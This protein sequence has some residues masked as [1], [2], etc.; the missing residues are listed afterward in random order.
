MAGK[1]TVLKK[2]FQEKDLQRLRNLVQGKTG[3]RTSTT[4]G[5]VQ[6]RVERREGEVWEEDGRKWELKGG[7]KQNISKLQELRKVNTFPIFCPK[8]KK[9]MD[10]KYDKPLYKIHQHCFECQ[11]QFEKELKLSGKYEEYKN[12]VHNSEIDGMIGK[13]EDWVEDLINGSNDGFVTEQGDVER[14]SKTN[15]KQIL[16]QKDQVLETLK[17]L[18][19]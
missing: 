18:K 7:V 5:Y 8:C 12:Q 4:S 16:S 2:E 19:K 10:E 13:Y 15:Y 9:K 17:K 1:D 11:L 14:W 3:E 6:K